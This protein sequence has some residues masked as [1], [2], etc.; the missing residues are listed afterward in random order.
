[1]AS[2]ET[3]GPQ[4]VDSLDMV[5][6]FGFGTPV[7]LNLSTKVLSNQIDLKLWFS[8]KTIDHK[9]DTRLLAC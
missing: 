4:F 6:H 2:P 8:A 3:G 1:M 5:E 7:E 9:C